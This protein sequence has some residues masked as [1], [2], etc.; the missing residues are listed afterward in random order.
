MRVRCSGRAR[1]GRY[2][3]YDVDFGRTRCSRCGEP[4]DAREPSDIDRQAASGHQHTER[5]TA[6]QQQ[7][8]EAVADP[9][10]VASAITRLRRRGGS[11]LQPLPGRVRATREPLPQPTVPRSSSATVS[12]QALPV[13][14]AVSPE[15]AVWGFIACRIGAKLPVPLGVEAVANNAPRGKKEGGGSSQGLPPSA[16]VRSHGEHD[17]HRSGQERQHGQRSQ[18]DETR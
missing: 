15:C 4:I 18:H 2:G 1:I 8:P 10:A 12:E 14:L 3:R 13:H 7:E 6:P 17:Q 9:T 16:C 11:S 5:A